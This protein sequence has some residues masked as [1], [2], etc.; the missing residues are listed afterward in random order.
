MSSDLDEL[1]RAIAEFDWTP[2]PDPE[3]RFYYDPATRKGT[4]LGG[5][6][7]GEY[8]LLTK[9]EYD[10]IGMA[11][12]FYVSGAGRVKPIPLDAQGKIMLELHAGGKFGTVKDCI[13]FADPTGPDQY[14][15]R[16]FYDD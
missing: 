11:F 2:A 5:D 1:N 4:V 9:P 13:I 3:F 12:H 7:P 6:G 10:K 14:K 16:D 8:V 15:I